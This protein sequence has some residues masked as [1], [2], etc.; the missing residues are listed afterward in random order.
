MQHVLQK[1]KLS[2]VFQLLSSSVAAA[3]G[4]TRP[5]SPATVAGDAES[6]AEKVSNTDVLIAKESPASGH[7]PYMT[8][9]VPGRKRKNAS[10][11]A[12]SSKKRG[13]DTATVSATV[14]VKEED[15]LDVTIV[16]NS[17]Q[18]SPEAVAA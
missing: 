1:N 4:V 15:V 6:V 7:A 16:A 9:A 12:R 8:I 2:A 14:V 11:I 17:S 18:L 5:S 3:F 10:T 13:L